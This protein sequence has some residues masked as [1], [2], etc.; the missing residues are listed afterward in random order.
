MGFSWNNLRMHCVAAKFV[1]CLLKED[2]K[3]TCV[4]VT[5]EHI[6]HAIADEISI[7]NIVTGDETWVYGFVVETKVQYSRRVSKT[8][9]RP[10]KICQVQSNVKMMLSMFFYCE[11][12]IYHEFLPLCQMAKR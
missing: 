4:D 7:K 9:P 1:L 8:S 10:Q 5:K 2:Q 6:K 12:I 3:Q 11:G